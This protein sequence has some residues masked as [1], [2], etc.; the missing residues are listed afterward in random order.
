LQF[1]LNLNLACLQNISKK[2]N[3]SEHVTGYLLAIGGSIP[4]FSTNLISATSNDGNINI[5]VGTISG[6]GSFGKIK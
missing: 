1:L 2:Y 3:L 5:G 6:S 4:E